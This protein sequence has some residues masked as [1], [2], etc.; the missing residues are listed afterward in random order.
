[1]IRR[2]LVCVLASLA[3]AGSLSIALPARAADDAAIIKEMDQLRREKASNLEK[4]QSNL[5]LKEKARKLDADITAHEATDREVDAAD[6]ALC[7]RWACSPGG[8]DVNKI[9]TCNNDAT[10]ERMLNDYN[11]KARAHNAQMNQLKAEEAELRNA[12]A[13]QQQLLDRNLQ[14]D[15]RLAVLNDKLR[16]QRALDFTA[17]RM[18]C[19]KEFQTLDQVHQDESHCWDNAVSASGV[20][21]VESTGR[22]WID[23]EARARAAID[24]YTRSGVRPGPKTFKPIVPPVPEPVLQQKDQAKPKAK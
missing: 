7:S 21:T 12:Y 4:L 15:T 3:I 14:I 10:C 6:Q 5:S 20:T 9:V 11:S 2:C 23:Q 8:T 13:A 17:A 16:A 19:D 24:K 22:V 1:M 18:K